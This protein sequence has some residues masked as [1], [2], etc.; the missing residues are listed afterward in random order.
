MKIELAH[1]IRELPPYLFAQ[2]RRAQERRAQEGDA[3]SSTSA[4]AIRIC[5]RRRT[6]SRRW[7]TA[8]RDPA[9]APLSVVRRHGETSA[10]A[11]AGFMKTR[12]GLTFDPAQRGDL[13]DRLEGSHRALPVR[14]RQPGRRRALP[15]P[16]LP[17]LRDAARGSRAASRTSCRCAARTASCPISTP[18]R[19]TSRAARRS[20]GSTTRT[21]RRRRWPR[22]A[23]TRR[24]SRSRRSTT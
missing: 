20:S 21:T 6:S 9:H 19:P 2:D 8:G 15:R 5:R 1:R 7:P 11:A 3:T 17:G 10:S 12:F 16:G 18:S 24:S 4:S 22:R 13:R 23:S 14:V